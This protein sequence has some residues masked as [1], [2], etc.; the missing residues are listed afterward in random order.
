MTVEH[1]RMGRVSSFDRLLPHRAAGVV[2]ATWLASIATPVLGTELPWQ[3]DS[4][5][6]ASERAR[7]SNDWNPAREPD[8]GSETRASASVDRTTASEPSA[9]PPADPEALH[10]MLVEAEAAYAEGHWSSALEAF[11]AVSAVDPANA[12]AWLRIGNLHHR[13]GQLQA[14]GDAYRRAGGNAAHGATRAAESI[15][16]R[17][18]RIKALINLASVEVELASAALDQAAALGLTA[19][20]SAEQAAT[21]GAVQE[22]IRSLTDR[23]GRAPEAIGGA[24]GRGVGDPQGAVEPGHKPTPTP[25]AKATRKVSQSAGASRTRRAV[26]TSTRGAGPVIEYLQGEPQQ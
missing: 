6:S 9:V 17:Q 25:T 14:A 1:R 24:G 10:R 26:R 2:L 22:Q 20:V 8:R 12:F 15:E 3:P 11:T 18:T 21:A 13:Q 7:S 4:F 23:I 16:I 19:P 5:R